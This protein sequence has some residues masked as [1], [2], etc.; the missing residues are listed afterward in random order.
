MCGSMQ[1]FLLVY[2]I[3]A[4]LLY[5]ESSN[6]HLSYHINQ[7]SNNSIILDIA[8]LY[9][10]FMELSTIA[11]LLCIPSIPCKED[12]TKFKLWSS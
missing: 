7:N 5:V 8:F 2:S 10:V 11:L 9:M 12:A 3:C 1:H 4:V 6:V